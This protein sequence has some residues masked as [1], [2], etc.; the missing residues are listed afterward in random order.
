MVL[1]AQNRSNSVHL[2]DF[3]IDFKF[4]KWNTSECIQIDFENV[5]KCKSDAR[6]AEETS[7]QHH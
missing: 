6:T 4:G 5:F 1:D 3:E 2:V 7:F